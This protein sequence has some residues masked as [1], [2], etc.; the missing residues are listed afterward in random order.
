[1]KT[2][3]F[4]SSELESAASLLR[5]S[6]LVAFPTETVYGLGANALDPGAVEKIYMAKGRPSDNPLIVHISNLH[7]LE[8]V[9][10]DVPKVALDLMKQFWPGPLT[11]VFPKRPTVP[12]G[13]TAGLD[14]VAVRFPDHPIAIKIIRLAKVPLAAPSANRSGRPSATTWQAVAEDLD[15][16]IAGVVCGEP[17]MFG[18]E[19]TVVDSTCCPPRVLRPGGVSLEQLAAVC[20]EMLP[21]SG[22]QPNAPDKSSNS[23]GIRH[24]H[25]QPRAKV[26]LVSGS[27]ANSENP[28]SE[29]SRMSSDGSIYHY[30]GL[31]PPPFAARFACVL[32][33]SDVSEYAA[34]LFDFFRKAD[35]CSADVVCCENVEEVGLGV[36][37]LDRIRRASQ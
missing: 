5:N 28:I 33:C 9:V 10:R 21:Y 6:E 25:Y 4:L 20:S 31:C 29:I 36:A 22:H 8:Q 30:I 12:A 34:Q 18:L 17:T 23:P 16:R 32:V 15:G 2:R 3:Y 7:Q 13:V 26:I 19:S 27:V 14:T 11:I 35:L 24:K 1:M 37:L